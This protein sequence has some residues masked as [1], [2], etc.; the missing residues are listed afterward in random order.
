MA[1]RTDGSTHHGGIKNEVRIVEKLNKGT[2]KKIYPNLPPT[3]T[4]RHMG[5]TKNTQDVSV[6]HGD[7]EIKKISVKNKS[8]GSKSGSYDYTN[9]SAAVRQFSALQ[10]Y[11]NGV[12]QARISGCS[13][14][15]VRGNLKTLS[16]DALNR[17]TSTDIKSILI[18]YVC[19]KYMGLDL[20]ISDGKTNEDY[21]IHFANTTLNHAIL[22]YTP[23]FKPATND[24]QTSRQIVFADHH[25]NTHDYGI[26]FRLVLNNGVGALLGLS[27]SNSNSQPVIKIQ[28]DQVSSL[29]ERNISTNNCIKF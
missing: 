14:E 3:V 6:F 28:Q 16:C 25:G 5:G 1:F 12:N 18:K 15:I 13:K 21:L 11:V 10:G 24:S 4:A 9:S 8:K 17:L 27:K 19:E 26:R 23:S 2:I 29:I 22:N 20:L 7:D